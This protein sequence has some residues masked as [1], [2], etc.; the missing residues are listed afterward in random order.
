MKRLYWWLYVVRLSL[1][2]PFKLNLGD[3]V[4]RRGKRYML[5]QG[6]CDPY[7]DLMADDQS[8]RMNH[9]HLSEFRKSWRLS[10]F[11]SSFACGY[12][13]YMGYWYDIWVGQGIKPY[14]RGCNIWG[15]A[16][17]KHQAKTK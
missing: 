17:H 14:M 11:W 5:I 16:K 4:W 8:E 3:Y 15:K 10:N 6:V 12:R 2:W 1:R 13:F 9:V 7:W